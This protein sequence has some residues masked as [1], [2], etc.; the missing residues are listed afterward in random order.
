MKI[1]ISAES[2]VDLTPELLKEYEIKTLPFTVLLGDK[3]GEDGD[4]TAEEIFKFVAENKI[5]PK[6]SAINEYQYNEYFTK[7]LQEGDAVIHFCLSSGISCA[8]AN[9]ARAAEH[10]ENVY[11]IDTKSLSTGIALL[12]IKAQKMARQGASVEEIVKTVT[13]DTTNLNVSFVIDKLD[14]LK[15]GGRCSSL[16]AFGANLL[17]LHP[18]IVVSNG[19]MV[20]GKKYRGTFDKVVKAYCE[21]VSKDF[22]NAD[23]S[24][25]FLTYTT[26]GDAAR[27]VA[28]KTLT[29]AC[30]KEIYE[31]N[32]GAT[33]TS[34]CGPNTLGLLFL[35][36]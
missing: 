32:A 13:T 31:T 11:V 23:K 29:E 9:A 34:H 21:D 16:A 1:I 2:T 10:F 14:Y 33:I 25:A 26:A 27:E 7:L 24:V 3:M 17:Q 20:S 19:K 15:K 12:A 4:I 36:K 8:Y 35:M 18:Q 5:L 30:F 28:L 22:E 6:T